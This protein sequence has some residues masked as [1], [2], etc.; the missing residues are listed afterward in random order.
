MQPIARF[1][2]LAHAIREPIIH[3]KREHV[4]IV[5]YGKDQVSATHLAYLPTTQE[6][7]IKK[8]RHYDT[9]K[10]DSLA[11]YVTRLSALENFKIIV[12][13]ESGMG[14]TIQSSAILIRKSPK[15]DI[16]EAELDDLVANAIWKI[17]DR[18]RLQ[19]ARALNVSD[20]DVLLGD[21]KA[22]AVKL[23]GHRVINPV[24]F[25]AKSVE[26]ILRQTYMPRLVYDAL[27]RSIPFSKVALLEEAGVSFL[28]PL[29][30]SMRLPPNTPFSLAHIDQEKVRIFDVHN[31]YIHPATVA[32]CGF[33]HFVNTCSS[34][35]S[36]HP[37]SFLNI[38]NF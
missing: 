23:D 15:E 34:L 30:S 36:F 14:R 31:L 32:S 4:L 1:L 18:E 35:Y 27:R 37:E 2:K 13:L 17:F 12:G 3:K 29:I 33:N 28:Q 6:I 19:S 5:G 26:I 8:H 11:Q 20:V 7:T 10:P 22:V 21:V 38:L 24:G 16:D 9:N 25:K